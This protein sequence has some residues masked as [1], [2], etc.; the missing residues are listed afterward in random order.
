MTSSPAPASKRKQ[1]LTS[2]EILGPVCTVWQQRRFRP[3]SIG[4]GQ[5]MKAWAA[6][7]PES[8]LT[9]RTIEKAMWFVT[10]R[11]EYLHQLKRGTVR[12]DLDGQPD[13][14]VTAGEAEHALEQVEVTCQKMQAAKRACRGNKRCHHKV[15][16]AVSGVLTIRRRC[17]GR[18]IGLIGM[19]S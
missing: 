13:G 14:V 11:L 10:T 5:K 16:A 3:V 7:H 2:G 17:S 12:Y 4:T 8:G 18:V 19:H 15:R 9:V 1:K 6:E